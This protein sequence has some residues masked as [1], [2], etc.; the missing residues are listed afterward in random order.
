M[1]VSFK[2]YLIKRGHFWVFWTPLFWDDLF[3]NEL[4]TYDSALFQKQYKSP[5]ENCTYSELSG[6]GE[7]YIECDKDSFRC[8]IHI[9]QIAQRKCGRLEIGIS[10]AKVFALRNQNQTFKQS[11]PLGQNSRNTGR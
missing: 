10:L 7:G 11:S 9:V 2:K 8:S 3:F 5:H 6:G 4:G 1:L